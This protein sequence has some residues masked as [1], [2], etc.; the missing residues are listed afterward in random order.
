M[1]VL[2]ASAIVDVIIDQ[3]NKT[4]LLDY[5]DRELV[6]PAHQPAEVLSAIA[7]LRRAGELSDAMAR[8]A[9]RD[10][11][12]LVQELVPLDGGLLRRALELD[13]RLRVV[14]ALYVALA[15]RL[16][17][18]LLTSDH[19]LAAAEPPCEIVLVGA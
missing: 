11:A 1:I 2:D 7:R 10:A 4:T 16:E 3:P 14:D 9:V 18:P 12:D 13:G 5:F 6:A 8:D 19:R 15:E 17:C